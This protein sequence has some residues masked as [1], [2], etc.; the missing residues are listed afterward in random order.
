M[1]SVVQA[2][3]ISEAGTRNVSTKGDWGAQSQNCNVIMA[4]P[5]IFTIIINQVFWKGCDFRNGNPFCFGVGVVMF[6]KVNRENGQRSGI[7]I[8]NN[9]VG[10]GEDMLSG[11]QGAS[12]KSSIL[13]VHQPHH[14]WIHV[15]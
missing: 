1:C 10:S 15:L 9:T 12:T 4:D 3:I 13:D 14:P 11:D 2:E 5:I 7:V 8:F 6:P